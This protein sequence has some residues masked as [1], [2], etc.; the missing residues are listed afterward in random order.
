M[1]N[2]ILFF[3]IVDHYWRFFW[4]FVKFPKI[5]KNF[6]N[7]FLDEL[8]IQKKN[9]ERVWPPRPYGNFHTFFF[10]PSLTKLKLP[11]QIVATVIL[12]KGFPE[13][14]G[15]SS[16]G[17]LWVFNSKGKR[18]A[19]WQ[20]RCENQ[21]TLVAIG[22]ASWASLINYDQTWANVLIDWYWHLSIMPLR[23]ISTRI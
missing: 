1:E 12:R 7:A 18:K 23:F 16:S 22:L 13:R 4:N 17:L 5:S 11:E 6:F 14:E 3:S 21:G 9:A 19:F 10:N 2:N 8:R 15:F 20:Y